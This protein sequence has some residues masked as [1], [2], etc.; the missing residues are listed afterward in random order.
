MFCFTISTTSSKKKHNSQII[1]YKTLY[2][3][4]VSYTKFEGEHE[5]NLRHII[6]KARRSFEHKL[7]V[8]MLK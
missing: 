2:Y 6:V 3:I 4:F 5:E 7:N 8:Y 1:S